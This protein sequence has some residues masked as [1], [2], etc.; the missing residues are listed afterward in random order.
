[1]VERGSSKNQIQDVVL[2]LHIKTLQLK[3]TQQTPIFVI[4][5]R[6]Q[7]KAK[8]NGRLLNESISQAVIDEKFQIRTNIEVTEEGLPLK[9]KMSKLYLVTKN[10]NEGH[11]AE[12]DL[13][14]SSF[15]EDG[16]FKY[17]K[18]PLKRCE[19]P[20]GYLE[21]GIQGKEDNRNLSQKS[22]NLSHNS[23]KMSERSKEKSKSPTNENKSNPLTHII[24][25]IEKFKKLQKVQ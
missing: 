19:D 14:L 17:R 18:L 9:P 12:A 6:G 16:Q 22:S 13:D 11:L 21:V 8:T 10:Q 3:V 25:E 7:K 15:P 20:D 2:T 4:W 1:M 5:Q 23:S 24:G